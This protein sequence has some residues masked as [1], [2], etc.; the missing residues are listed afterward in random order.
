MFANTSVSSEKQIKMARKTN[1]TPYI[2]KHGALLMGLMQAQPQFRKKMIQQAPKELIH[3]ISE[4]CQNV[5]K[6]NVSLSNRQKQ[7]LKS[8]RHHLR[9]LADRTVP[10]PKKKKILNQQGGFLPLLALAPSIAHVI[11]TA[12][13]ELIRKI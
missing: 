11:N 10:V 6:G 13:T 2:K 3:C 12:L 1:K 7:Q 4:C 9:Q 8:K 5:L